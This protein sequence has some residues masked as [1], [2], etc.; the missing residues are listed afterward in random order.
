MIDYSRRYDFLVLLNMQ[1]I[2]ISLINELGLNSFEIQDCYFT[3]R[4]KSLVIA[5]VIHVHVLLVWS[6]QSI[7]FG[8]MFGYI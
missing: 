3:V 1:S 4:G 8:L 7:D 6:K 2:R 5:I